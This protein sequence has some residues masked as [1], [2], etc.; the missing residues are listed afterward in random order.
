MQRS[1]H[2]IVLWTTYYFNTTIIQGHCHRLYGW[3][4][5]RKCED[6]NDC[7]I[8]SV[9]EIILMKRECNFFFK[10]FC[11]LLLSQNYFQLELF[12][13]LKEM[14]WISFMYPQLWIKVVDNELYMLG[15]LIGVRGPVKGIVYFVSFF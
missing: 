12:E 2:Y 13:I 6:D 10:L 15:V 8:N 1:F 5:W 3:N 14:S 4:Y 7:D 11:Q 9:N